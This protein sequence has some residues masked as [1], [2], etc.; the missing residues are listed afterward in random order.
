MFKR[1]FMLMSPNSNMN[2]VLAVM[3]LDIGLIA[4]QQS[5]P[6]YMNSSI[7]ALGFGFSG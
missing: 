5:F 2:G 6:F 1:P 4:L 7:V 3:S